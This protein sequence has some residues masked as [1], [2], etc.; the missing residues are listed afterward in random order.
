MIHRLLYFFIAVLFLLSFVD[1]AKK[2]TPSGGKKDTIPPVITKSVPDNY[3][4]NFDTKEI[5]IHFD[6]YI[7]LKDL[8]KN[9]IIS[10]PLKYPP[11]ITPLNTSKVIKIKIQDTLA[12]NTTYSIN[13]GQSIVDNNEENPFE[14]FKYVFSTGP[15]LDS[16]TLSGKVGD[17]LLQKPSSSAKVLLYE[18]NE[19]YNDSMVYSEKPMYITTVSDSTDTFELTNLKEGDYMLIA[20]DEKANDYTF[21]PISDKIGFAN[22]IITIPTDETF[23]L[24]LFKEKK[25]F[26]VARPQHVTK[27]HILFGYEGDI[28]ELS[29]NLETEVS[30][31][32]ESFIYKD[33]KA[34]SLHYWF[35]PALELDTLVFTASYKERIDTLLVRMKNLYR[36]SLSLMPLNPSTNILPLDTI[37]LRSNTPLVDLNSNKIKII[38]KDSA[39]IEVSGHINRKFNLAELVFPKKEEQTYKI[40]LLPGTVTD[41]YESINDTLNFTVRTKALSDYGSLTFNIDPIASSSLIIQLVDSKYN[42]V[43]E[44]PLNDSSKVQFDYIDPGNYFVRVV[45]D[46]NN[47]GIW[48]TG[49]FLK[50]IQPEKIIYYPSQ[51]EVRAN[52]SLIESFNLN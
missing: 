19:M 36:D 20:L 35:K 23:N 29:V 9:L 2:G 51:I 14:Y 10:P 40:Q 44:K 48:D 12:E 15:Y 31:E 50:R 41:I 33:P 52:W 21:Q 32:F 13:F 3:S 43:N 49:S 27:T 4:S 17:A 6:E 39:E 1:C 18:V 16:L 5:R 45:Y 8:Q 28:K 42:V 24:S 25:P 37:K 7:K 22:N 38:D 30:E 46:E 26:K 34:D 47:N 11:V